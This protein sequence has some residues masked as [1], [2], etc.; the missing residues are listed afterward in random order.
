M[1][2]PNNHPEMRQKTS[3]FAIDRWE[4]EGGAHGHDSPIFTMAAVSRRIAPGRST[5][6]SPGFRP[7][8]TAAP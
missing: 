3:D 5:M 7:A 6:S 8:S 4:N 2:A 1:N